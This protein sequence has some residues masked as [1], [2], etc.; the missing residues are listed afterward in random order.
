MIADGTIM[1]DTAGEVIGQIN[2]LAVLDLGDVA[3][4]RPSRITATTFQGRA[5]I[6]NI[7]RESRMSGRIHDKGV[8]ILAGFLGGR[9]AQNKPLSLSASITFEQSYEGVDGDERV[10]GRVVRAPVEP[11]R[12]A[13]EARDRG[14]RLREPTTARSSR[15]G[16]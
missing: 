16:A 12:T 11:R 5:G 1:V 8:L 4:G 6:V 9:Y 2:G 15:S 7:E 14:N 13:R 10:V 3:F